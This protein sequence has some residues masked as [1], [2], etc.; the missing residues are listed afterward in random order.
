MALTN[1][2]AVVEYRS[3]INQYMLKIIKNKSNLLG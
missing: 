3:E 2:S 1:E